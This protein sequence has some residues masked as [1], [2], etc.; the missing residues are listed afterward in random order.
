M[1][2]PDFPRVVY[3]KNPLEEVICQ[4]RF[5]PIL[6]IDTE[7]PAKFQE[8]IRDQYP[9]FEEK[10]E[11]V[12][13]ISGEMAR[14]LP[15][16]LLRA[17]GTGIADKKAYNFTSLDEK[18][19]VSLTRDFLALTSNDYS[20]WEAFSDHFNSPLSELIG[21]YKP[22]LFSR[23]GLRYRNIIRRSR[24]G[25]ADNTPW[26]AL[27]QPYIAGM[28]S[29]LNFGDDGVVGCTHAVEVVLPDLG[30][31]TI[32][33][34]CVRDEKTKEICYLIDSD[35]FAEKIKES[36]DVIDRLNKFNVQARNLF[37]WCIADE[38][39]RAMDPQFIG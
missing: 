35:F 29:V 28:L 4:I 36:K 20:R 30:R 27:L 3:S 5:P 10:R 8:V 2:F 21:E 33:H 34:G 17:M 18:W 38:L 32:R 22:T 15:V 39:H 9:L 31:V 11:I 25:L 37:R 16:E 24:L 13:E 7:V 12:S 23:V 26:S 6:R 1:A 14:M 19:I